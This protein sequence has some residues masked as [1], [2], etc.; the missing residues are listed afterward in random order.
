MGTR[1]LTEKRIPSA[2]TRPA[3]YISAAEARAKT[4]KIIQ[5]PGIAPYMELVYRMIQEAIE[6]KQF[7]VQDPQERHGPLPLATLEMKEAILDALE[8]EG[9]KIERFPEDNSHGTPPYV[10]V[11]WR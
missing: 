3:S 10:N 7:Y 9:Y 4:Q 8:K 1:T 5:G 6:A 11:S 2:P